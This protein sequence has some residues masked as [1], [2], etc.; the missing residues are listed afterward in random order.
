MRESDGT[1][2]AAVW[3]LQRDHCRV[4]PRVNASSS[5]TERQR[6]SATPQLRLVCYRPLALRAPVDDKTR[7]LAYIARNCTLELVPLLPKR[8]IEH[9]PEHW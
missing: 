5:K 1:P 7:L 8:R 6:T 9:T 4:R 3:G 2:W